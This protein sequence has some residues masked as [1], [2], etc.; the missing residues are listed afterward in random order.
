M[1]AGE[2]RR[3]LNTLKAAWSAT[4]EQLAMTESDLGKAEQRTA[5][6]AGRTSVKIKTLEVGPTCTFSGYI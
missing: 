3:Q 6:Q 1:E 2:N 4:K 5:E